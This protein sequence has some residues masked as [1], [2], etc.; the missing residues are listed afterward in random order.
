VELEG[1][2][3]Q[4]KDE[5]A[6]C[7][8]ECERE[9]EAVRT[10]TVTA[11]DDR[12]GEN[13]S[14]PAEALL[15]LRTATEQLEAERQTTAELHESLRRSENRESELVEALEEEEAELEQRSKEERREPRAATLPR[16]GNGRWE[17]REQ[18]AL[19]EVDRWR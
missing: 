16:A 4:S 5:V 15:C 7:V 12:G 13:P 2:H 3:E 6:S 17:A 10:S 14:E 1:E 19:D 8:S 11:T 9:M 18:R